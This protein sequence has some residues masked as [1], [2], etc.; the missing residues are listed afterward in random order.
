[1]RLFGASL[2]RLEDPRLLRGQGTFVEDLRLPGLR[3]VAFV[4]SAHPPARS[5]SAAGALPDGA[6]LSPAAVSPSVVA[7]P[8]VVPHEALRPCAQPPLARGRVRYVGEPLA[9]VVAADRYA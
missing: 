5:R 2:K 7:I 8:A 1:M 3:H 4:R 9:A 6:A